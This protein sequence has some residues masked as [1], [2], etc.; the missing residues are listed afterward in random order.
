MPDSL[1]VAGLFAGVG[2]IEEGLHRAGHETEILCESWEPAVGVLKDRFPGLPV[3]HDVR[4]LQSL[5]DVDLIAAGFPCQDL[6]QAGRTSGIAGKQSGLV[7]HVFRLLDER[8]PTWLLLENVLFMLQLDRGG[9]MHFLVDELEKRRYR[10]AYRVVDSRFTGVPQ[11]RRRVILLASRVEDPRSVLFADD[12]G[13]PSERRYRQDAFGFYWTE[14]LRGL[15]WAVDAVPTLKGGS[16]V[17]IP[18]PP[19]V[20]IPGADAG[21]QLVVPNID[22]A[23]RLQ[24]FRAGWTTAAADGRRDG[25]RWKLVGN[26]VTVGVS[27]WIGRRLAEPGEMQALS[28][29][30][31]VKGAWPTAAWG[32]K[33]TVYLV[34]EISEYPVHRR[35]RHLL[36]VV[37]PTRSSPLSVRAASGFLSRAEQSSLRFADGFLVSV[38]DH[39]EVL[40]G[41]A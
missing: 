33:G 41:G 9:A 29:R 36:D 39:I 2:G 25:K 7:E 40:S 14:G 5:P 30:A 11:R 15:G 22:A 3:H 27:E 18:S 37:D 38:A 16:S 24:G 8:R 20:W 1:R 4:E 23:E 17:G 13:E 32:E 10:W 28:V 19:A 21:G 6:S 34:P 26:A 12:A 31:E 35:Y